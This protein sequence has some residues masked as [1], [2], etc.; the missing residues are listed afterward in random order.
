MQPYSAMIVTYTMQTLNGKKVLFIITKSN[1]G[2]AQKYVYELALGV[3]NAGGTPVVACG[4]TGEKKGDIGPLVQDLKIQNISVRIVQNFMRNMSPLRDLFALLEL[5]SI[6]KKE[7]PD[8]LHVT[9]SKAGGLG[10]FAGRLCGVTNIIFTSHGLTFQ[11]NWRPTYQ[12]LAI[13]LLTWFTLILAHHSIM[14]SKDTYIEAKKLPWVSKKIYLIYNGIIPTL[15][16]SKKEARLILNPNKTI[17]D[18]IWVGGIGELHPNKN[19]MLLIETM[20]T[21]PESVYC[22]IIGEGEERKALEDKITKL[23]LQ[24]RVLLPGF[25]P[26]ASSLL[27]AFDIFVLPS[28][29][30]GLPYVLLEAGMAKC[31]VA[32]STISGNTDIIQN[33]I[34]G[35]LFSNST[36]SAS[37]AIL[38]LIENKTLRKELGTKLYTDVHQNFSIKFMLEKTFSLYTNT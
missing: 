28:K 35:V 11:E 3:Q 12:K 33:G 10:A 17:R 18:Q 31:T 23:R 4:N 19:W 9:S 13:K 21:L 32:C 16:T 5:I 6:I 2:G 30:E 20:A 14:I 27:S 22:V 37:K 24:H 25:I 29:K 34:N 26:N 38:N 36:E 1:L 8:V 7:R 15:L